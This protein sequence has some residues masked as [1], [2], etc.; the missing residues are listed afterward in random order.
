MDR[1][2]YRMVGVQPEHMSILVN[3]SS[4]HFRADFEAIAAAI[5]VARAPGVLL[6]DPADLPWR[7]LPGEMRLK[8]N[9]PRFSDVR[10]P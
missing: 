5:L 10:R 7:R 8:P 1:N 3:K 6:A 9:G 2:Q 4:V